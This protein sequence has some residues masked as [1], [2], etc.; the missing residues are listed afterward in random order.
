ASPRAPRRAPGLGGRRCV[1]AL[2][3]GRSAGRPWPAPD[4]RAPPP[5][6]AAA[7]S[8]TP[9][10]A[11][12]EL[13]ERRTGHEELLRDRSRRAHRERT[14]FARARGQRRRTGAEHGLGEE[15]LPRPELVLDVVAV[16]ELELT[17]A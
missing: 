10:H 3:P 17:D 12:E 5:R 8:P 1:A 9:S 14:A 4:R 11:G 6:F 2:A 13:Q 15:K 16:G 7:P